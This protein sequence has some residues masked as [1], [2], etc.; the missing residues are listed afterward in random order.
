[1]SNRFPSLL[2]ALL[3]LL[4]TITPAAAQ[5][6][7]DERDFGERLI[8]IVPVVGSGTALDR[9]RPLFLPGPDDLAAGNLV[10]TTNA[11]ILIGSYVSDYALGRY[12]PGPHQLAQ[13]EAPVA[14]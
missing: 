13:L 9:K 4:S 7:V 10:G 2:V 11:F 5:R 1:M 6:R 14:K 3:T 8:L 12:C